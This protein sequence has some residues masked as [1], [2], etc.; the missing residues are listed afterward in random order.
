M[1]KIYISTD[2]GVKSSGGT[3]ANNELDA[4]KSLAKETNDNVIELS[5]QDIHPTKHNLPD[6][7][8]F[9]DLLTLD[10]LNTMDLSDVDLV[11]MYGG[12]YLQTI[13]MLKSKNIKTTNTVMFHNREISISE[14]EKFFGRYPY[15]YVRYDKLWNLFIGGIRYADIAIASGLHPK[16]NM[17]KEGAKRVEIIPLGCDIPTDDKIKPLPKEFRVGYLGEYGPDKGISYLIKSWS[18][19]NYPDSTLIFAGPHSD[20]LPMFINHIAKTGNFHIRGY[21]NDVA[22]F[23]NNISVYVQPSATEAFGLEV[24]EAMSYGR[25]VIVS[26]GAGA[27]DCV[28]DGVDGFIVP[29][30]DSNA[31]SEKIQYFKD[32]PKQVEMMGFNARINSLKYSWNRTKDGYIRMWDSLIYLDHK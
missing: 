8:L 31:I 7:P 25:P 26:D 16:Q 29:K 13:R 12:S 18:S 21:V 6:N 9:I 5:F 19:L 2:L 1:T 30:M 10:K 15:D 17:I 14:H 28:T 24:P 32:N 20:Q 23:Y 11:H 4:L 27:A 22:D 3:V